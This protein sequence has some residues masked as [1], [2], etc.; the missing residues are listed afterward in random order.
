MVAYLHIE[1]S[2][3]QFSE[4]S[5]GG[6][7]NPSH[8]PGPCGTEKSVVLRGLKAARISTPVGYRGLFSHLSYLVNN[9]IWINIERCLGAEGTSL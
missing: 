8:P 3:Y 9:N 6:G 1:Y 2:T 5:K 4:E 7:G